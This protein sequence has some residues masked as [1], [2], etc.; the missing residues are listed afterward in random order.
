MLEVEYT[1]AEGAEI[2]SKGLIEKYHTHLK[3]ANI[4]YLFRDKATKNAGRVI[5]GKATKCSPMNRL[6]HKQDFVIIFAK[7][8]WDVLN[9]RQ[10][11][12]LVDHELCHCG[13]NKFDNWCILQHDCEEF[14]SVI[15][16]H[17]D[18]AISVKKLIAAI[19]GE[20]A[21]KEKE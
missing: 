1:K 16:R 18:S 4:T 20:K 7:D 6:L 15:E 17:G 11:E 9:E 21:G 14:I 3:S 2:I 19:K 5:L 13:K 10:R 12:S 8:V